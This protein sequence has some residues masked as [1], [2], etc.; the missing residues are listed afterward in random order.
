[1]TFHNQTQGVTD[2]RLNC[3]LRYSR[4]SQLRQRLVGALGWICTAEIPPYRIHPFLCCRTMSNSPP[5][6]VHSTPTARREYGSSTSAPTPQ[7]LLARSPRVGESSPPPCII[8]LERYDEGQEPTVEE[9]R[10]AKRRQGIFDNSEMY[11]HQGRERY[12]SVTQ[13]EQALLHVAHKECDCDELGPN[14]N[15]VTWGGAWR[16][17][18][19][20]NLRRI[21]YC[22][23]Y[24]DCSCPWT[25][26]YT[27]LT[28]PTKRIV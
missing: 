9:E 18:Q 24:T 21:G 2:L 22:A 14:N 8:P 26:S 1:M 3:I 20:T 19:K 23:Y 25:V 15:K 7:H 12:E 5:S 4:R 6:S 28:L 17:Y 16:V 11:Q 27:H 13:F 10:H